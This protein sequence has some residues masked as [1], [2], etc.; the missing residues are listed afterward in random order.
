MDKITDLPDMTAAVYRGR[1]ALTQ[2]FHKVKQFEPRHEK[3]NVL[4]M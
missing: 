2:N 1:K 4:H 3:T